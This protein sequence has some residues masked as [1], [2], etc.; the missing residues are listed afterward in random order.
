[1][2]KMQSLISAKGYKKEEKKRKWEERETV[3]EQ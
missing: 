2:I 1:M 3:I